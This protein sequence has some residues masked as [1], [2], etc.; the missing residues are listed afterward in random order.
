MSKRKY[1]CIECGTPVFKSDSRCK[2]CSADIVRQKSTAMWQNPDYRE[3][4]A[5]KIKEAKAKNLKPPNYCIDCGVQISR[6]SKRCRKCRSQ[7]QWADSQYQDRVS[8]G[9]KAA[10]ERGGGLT[11]EERSQRISK[12]IAS[13]HARGDYGEE[14]I[15]KKRKIMLDAWQDNNSSY[16]T[17]AWSKSLSEGIKRAYQE[18]KIIPSR[19]S[20]E[21]RDSI[22]NSVKLRW[23]SG[24]YDGVFT[25]DNHRKK[26]RDA[27]L[28]MWEDGRFSAWSEERKTRMSEVATKRWLDGD[29]DHV[30]HSP[31][32]IESK[33]MEA[34]DSYR[35]E[36]IP[37]FRPPETTFPY[38][39]YIPSLNL[40]IEVDGW[41]W[42]H[43]SFAI[44]I[45][46][47]ER[48]VRKTQVAKD[49]GYN[50]IRFRED[51]LNSI[52]ANELVK[53]LVLPL[54]K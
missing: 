2:P 13:A 35:I 43:S 34:L 1:T 30:Y 53:T 40:L 47:P 44:S 15:A 18:G 28:K 49:L 3:T 12:A 7:Y 46:A 52:G 22:S 4:I 50:I 10:W 17:E 38:D 8:K 54:K 5:R 32:G 41:Y 48:D 51:D 37:Q 21:F 9:M 39:I 31:T 24:L 14:W 6:R 45:G 33:V 20:Q 27:T 36:Y 25:T 23:E 16:N 11:S 26:Q 42:H 19:S 29:F